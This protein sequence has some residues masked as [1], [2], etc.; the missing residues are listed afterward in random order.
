MK[1]IHQLRITLNESKP[2]IWRRIQVDS[3][4]TF[5]ELHIA[6]QLAMGWTNSHLFSFMTEGINIEIPTEEGEYFDTILPEGGRKLNA[7]QEKIENYFK[8][9]GDEITYLYDFGDS[10]E[11]HV[12]L[13]KII[14]AQKEIKYPVC[15][16]G[17]MNCPHEDSGGINGFYEK[18]EILNDPEHHEHKEIATWLGENYDPEFFDI[19]YANRQLTKTTAYLNEMIK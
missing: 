14:P 1:T 9:A 19:D 10:W 7:L 8:E 3:S 12:I 18:L 15:I 11:H 4:A 13:E 2:L 5:L 6:I 16:E 17:N